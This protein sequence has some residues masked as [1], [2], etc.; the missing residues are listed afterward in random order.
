MKI[1]PFSTA[2]TIDMYN[3]LKPTQ[4]CFKPEN[5]VLYVG[6]N[7]ISLRRLKFIGISSPIFSKEILKKESLLSLMSP[8]MI[9]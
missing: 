7:N 9:V 6:T 5:F 2:K 8:N 4:R 1:R 3:Y